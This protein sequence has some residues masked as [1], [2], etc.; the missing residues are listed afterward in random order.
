M[1]RLTEEGPVKHTRL[2]GF[3]N[4]TPCPGAGGIPSQFEKS[5]DPGRARAAGG[6]AIAQH[7][8]EP[9]VGKLRLGVFADAQKIAR[10]LGAEIEIKLSA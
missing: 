6:Y 10:A 8:A 9:G 2:Y 5:L 1:Q 7:R 3:K 4:R